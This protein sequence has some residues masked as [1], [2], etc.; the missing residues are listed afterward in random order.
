[1]L[2]GGRVERVITRQQVFGRQA[3]TKRSAVRPTC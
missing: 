3:M 1:L 2:G